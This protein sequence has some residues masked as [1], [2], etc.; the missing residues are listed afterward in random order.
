MELQNLSI[1]TV[2]FLRIGMDL[3]KVLEWV[4]HYVIL[5]S[6]DC[7]NDKDVLWNAYQT[8]KT[9]ADKHNKELFLT[10]LRSASHICIM[11]NW[12]CQSGQVSEKI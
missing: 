1:R 4:Q 2:Y 5:A 12:L 9:N 6:A 8:V 3:P 11:E 10:F 7:I